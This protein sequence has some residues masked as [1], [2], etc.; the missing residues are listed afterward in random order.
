MDVMALASKFIVSK[1]KKYG[2]KVAAQGPAPEIPDSLPVTLKGEKWQAG[3]ARAEIMPDLNSG[4]T[5]YIAGHGSGHVM[6]GVLSP[7]Y[8]H[9]VWLAC[10]DEEGVLWLSADVVG[11][12]RI[13]INKIRSMIT[14]SDIIKGC[15]FINF[16][17]THSHSGI[18]TL[19]YW[20]K[21]NL[22]SIPADGKDPDYM[23]MLMKTA[24]TVSEEAYKNRRPGRFFAGDILVPGGLLTKREFIDKHE[25]LSRF[26]FA[27]DDGGN[28]IWILNF[29]GHPNSLGGS[30]RLLSGE[31]PYF[32]REQIK[33][34][35]GAD[36]LF[37]IGAI[38]GMDV[39][40]TDGDDK[41]ACIKHQGAMLCEYSQ[42]IENDTE[43]EPEIKYINQPFYMPVDNNVLT[44]LATRKVMSF[45]AYPA[46]PEE[47]ELGICTQ[48]EMTYITLGGRKILCLPGENFVSTVYGSYRPAEDSATGEGPEINPTP[49]AVLADDPKL[50][51]FGVTN[52]M[53]GYVVPPNEFILNPTQPY[54]NGYHDRFDKNHYHETNSM[55]PLSQKRI[56][57]TFEKVLANFN[58]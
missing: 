3:F 31:F 20:G 36:V 39:A 46:P 15:K 5:Y 24:V 22:V 49:L 55:G 45:R 16:S 23:E 6:E 54:L 1:M 29:G 37:G 19:G 51:V 12:T 34:E 56:A 53:T 35:C 4:K 42:K 27:P 57:D 50:I 41:V 9:A 2:R 13:E 10:S 52:D 17:C 33:E 25:Y 38:G 26:R 7:V 40:E 44:L 58:S 32:M 43:L 47:S 30:N 28:E 8:I 48:T 14:D 11:M 21:P 18:D